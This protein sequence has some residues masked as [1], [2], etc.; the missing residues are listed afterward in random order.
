[1]RPAHPP[2][3]WERRAFIRPTR[4]PANQCAPGRL[5]AASTCSIRPFF[6]G[7]APREAAAL[8]PQQRILLEVAWEALEH[9]G[10]PPARLAGTPAGVFIG[11][12]TSEYAHL[13]RACGIEA[14]GSH[15]LSGTHVNFAAGRI[16]YCLGLNGPAMALDTACSSS[17]AAV[18]VACQSL[19]AGDCDLALAGGVNL[20]LTPDGCVTATKIRM[21][22][23]DGRCKT[24][25]ARA[26]GFVRGEGCGVVVLKPLAA[27][28]A[29]GDR[30]F[31]VI[32][33]SAANQDG[34]SGGSRCPTSRRR[35]GDPVAWRGAGVDR[36]RRQCRGA[37]HGTA[38]ASLELPRGR[39]A[40]PDRPPAGLCRVGETN[41]GLLNAPR[42]RGYEGGLALHHGEIPPHLNFERPNRT[43]TVPN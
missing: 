16:A 36:R 12:G 26:D 19:R 27:A 13:L 35:S 7:I 3:R 21:L 15:H 30:I 29:G 22:A 34:A 33:G 31:A 5:P 8:D 39:G 28:L 25:D 2:N 23:A 17:L 14:I 18:H 1:M 40:V 42:D 6:F 41:I 9:A 24:F 10:L 20:I 43:S 38:L 32:R 4:A 11:V 37:R